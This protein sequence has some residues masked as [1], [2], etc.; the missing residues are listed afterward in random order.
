MLDIE[1]IRTHAAEVKSAVLRKRLDVDIDR[2]LAVDADRRAAI[3]DTDGARQRRNELSAAIPKLPPA[4]KAPAVAEA[5]GLR[6]TIAALEARLAESQ[7]EF[8]RLM[9]LVPSVPSQEVPDGVTDDDNRE[10]RRFGEPRTFDFT[11]KDHVELALALGLVDFE[12]PRKFAGSRSY[13]LTGDGVLLE[14]AVLNFALNHVVSK[15]FTAVAPPVMVREQAMLGTGFFPLGR[16]DTFAIEQDSLYLVGTSE[17]GLVS[18][19]REQI[20]DE[21]DLPKRYVGISPC[22]R[23]EAGAA[24]KDTRGLYRVYQFQKIEQVVVCASDPAVS[25]R[26]H[27]GLLGNAEEILRALNIPHRVALACT[28]EMGQGQ[29]LKHEIESWMPSR[30]KYCETHSCSTLHEFQA[31]RSMIRWRDA[32]EKVRYCH[33]LNNTA[34]ASPRILIPI[35]ENFQEADGSV[36]IPEPLRYWMGGRDRLVPKK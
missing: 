8:D 30:G 1:F 20:L 12:G 2:L 25:A 14:M 19:H 33:T 26:E 18:L 28:G 21:K 22:F 34:I 27:L 5:K 35:L 17:V 29:V 24:G 3:R 9:L 16:E 10:V 32:H 6:D 31:R 4:E 36:V 7:A 23:R 15:G 11:A 13:A